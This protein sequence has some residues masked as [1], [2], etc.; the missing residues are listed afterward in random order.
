MTSTAASGRL[1]QRRRTP[2]QIGK[3]NSA[4]GKYYEREVAKF[5]QANGF[6]E[7]KRTVR[8]GYRTARNMSADEG[9]ICG[10]PGITWQVKATNES[11]WWQLPQWLDSTRLQKE[12]SGA[13]YGILVLKR[14][15]NADPGTWWVH[16]DLADVVGMLPDPRFGDL[17]PAA[18]HVP[19]RLELH[20]MVSILRLAGYGQAD[21]EVTP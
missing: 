1:D 6:P 15:G 2:A 11:R 13:E 20:H 17:P 12:A 18:P 7:A 16:I 5:L 19:I 4:K 9:D 3:A 8:T 10:T 14:K 21:G